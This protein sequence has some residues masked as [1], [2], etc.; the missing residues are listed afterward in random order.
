MT[1]S[2]NMTLGATDAEL[3]GH[4]SLHKQSGRLLNS[5]QKQEK[6]DRCRGVRSA[7]SPCPFAA[8]P[9]GRRAHYADCVPEPVVPVY[10]RVCAC[11]RACVCVCL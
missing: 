8:R 1:D 4:Q 5:L 6:R 11:V 2:G 10:V 9:S 3:H 7:A